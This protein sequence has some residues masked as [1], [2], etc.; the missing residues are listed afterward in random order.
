MQLN[1]KEFQKLLS[2]EQI[3][4]RIQELADQIDQDFAEDHPLFLP[5]LNGSF[6]FASDLLHH[7]EIPAEIDF[8]KVKSYKGTE[9]GDPT[10]LTGLD[11][12]IK[13]KTVIIIEDIIDT[14]QTI[15]FL[16]ENLKEHEPKQIKICTLLSKPEN[17]NLQLDYIGFEIPT[18]FVVGYGLDYDGKGRELNEIYT[19]T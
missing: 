10:E 2:K 1:N 12:P 13:D 9:S 5:V 15:D 11:T 16:L 18:K 4:T 17:H 14:G 8:I 19:L 7:I 3:Q 6:R